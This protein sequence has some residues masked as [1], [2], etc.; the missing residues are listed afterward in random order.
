VTGEGERESD[1]GAEPEP[2]EDAE[3]H[4]FVA[5][6]GAARL[7]VY[8]AERM[9]ALSR[10]QVRR[11]I[12]LG[13]ITVGGAAAAKAGQKLR[14]GDEVVVRVPP[15]APIDVEAEAIPLVVVF[16]DAHLIAIDKPAGMVVHPAPGHPS[17]TLV[18]ALLAHCGESLRG[19][20]GALR[21]GIVHR[22]DG[23][24]TGVM[25]AAKD[26]PTHTALAAMFKAKT[27][28]VREY[29][30]VVAPA[31]PHDAGTIRTLYGRHPVHRKKFSSKVARGK[32][33]VTHWR[34]IERFADAAMVRCRLE[35]G[36]THQIRVH[37]ADSGW[38]LLGDPLYG[39]RRLDFGRQALHAERLDF[40][41][42]ATGARL[43]LRAAIA[44]DIARLIEE[45]R[46]GA[47]TT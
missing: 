35:T 39:K 18:N 17:G 29:V 9:P 12:D 41:H 15:P 19:I 5:D 22:L 33:A 45:L 32:P 37:M 2:E 24:T 47:K 13:E 40:T 25:V 6:A 43:E 38:P 3:E 44:E 31:P 10:A 20:G 28:V 46:G 30:A 14:A 27:D 42:P 7:D 4:V 23:G 8:V 34:V 11:L 26:G 36:R 21:P 1:D 16:E